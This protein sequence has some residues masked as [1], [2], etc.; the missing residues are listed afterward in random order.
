VSDKI[1]D[2]KKSEDLETQA[3]EE[4]CRRGTPIIGAINEAQNE[5][6]ALNSALS[7]E[8]QEV[9]SES[10]QEGRRN[11]AMRKLIEAESALSELDDEARAKG[12]PPGWIRCNFD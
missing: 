10:R 3:R 6:E 2:E 1:S 7:K 4:W 11:S 12:V 9:L 8:G 5:I